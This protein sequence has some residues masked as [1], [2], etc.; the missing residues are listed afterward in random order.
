MQRFQHSLA[1][2]H[3]ETPCCFNRRPGGGELRE[4]I[5]NHRLEPGPMRMGMQHQLLR[6]GSSHKITSKVVAL[7]RLKCALDIG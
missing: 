4:E 1:N 6:H 7:L 5:I 2:H 3:G